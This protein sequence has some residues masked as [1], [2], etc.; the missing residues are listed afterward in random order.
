MSHGLMVFSQNTTIL[1]Q[2]TVGDLVS[3][4]GLVS[5][6]RSSTAPNDLTLTEITFPGNITIISQ[7]NS[8]TPLVLGKDR[9]PPTQQLSSLDNL[10]DGF[11]SVPNNSTRLDSTNPT[12][13]PTKFG[14]DFWESLEGQLVTVAKPFSL[15]FENRFGEFWVRGNW[16]VTG[17]NERG[18]LTITFG[19]FFDTMSSLGV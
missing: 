10:G 17:L 12:L 7:N 16:K 14:L 4:S 13:Q 6:F 11:L 15:N 18:G 9:S 5:E 2:V 1:G 8:I 19:G 3:L